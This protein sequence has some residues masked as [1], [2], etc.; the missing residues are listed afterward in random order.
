MD[1]DLLDIRRLQYCTPDVV[2]PPAPERPATEAL[3]VSVFDAKRIAHRHEARHDLQS[4]M[5][6]PHDGDGDRAVD[7]LEIDLY[8]TGGHHVR[9]WAHWQVRRIPIRA[10]APS[11]N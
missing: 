1:A 10:P 9:A 4:A 8:R 7:I 3:H 2:E 5:R 6:R 11:G